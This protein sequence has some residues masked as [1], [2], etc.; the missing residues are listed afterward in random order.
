MLGR[1]LNRNYS[2]YLVPT[3]ADI[4]GLDVVFVDEFDEEPAR[5]GRKGSESSPRC[6]WRTSGTKPIPAPKS[7]TVKP[8]PSI[9]DSRGSSRFRI[10]AS[11]S[12]LRVM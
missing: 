3:N 12:L 8:A 7:Q 4:P 2:G 9:R 11:W 10:V 6:R 5:F 1:F